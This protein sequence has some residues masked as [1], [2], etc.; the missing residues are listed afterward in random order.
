LPRALREEEAGGR[1]T[2]GRETERKRQKNKKKR[3]T[4]VQKMPLHIFN[5]E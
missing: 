3:M 2:G 5:E 1:G 4:K